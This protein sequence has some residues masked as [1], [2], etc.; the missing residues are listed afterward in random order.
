MRAKC[1]WLAAMAGAMALAASVS[2]AAAGDIRPLQP[3]A[4][5]L[6][7]D[8]LRRSPS[9]AALVADLRESDVVVYVDLEGDER[10]LLGALRF[11]GAAGGTRF[12]RVWLQPRSSDHELV[13]LL[14]HE[15]QHAVELAR[16]PSARS[17]EAFE[18]LFQAIGRSGR[19][20]RYETGAAQEVA[21]RV[22]GELRTG[23]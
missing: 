8:G 6:L 16:T 1:G 21:E 23:R 17:P 3:R 7:E 12:V 5:R 14:A 22:R 15:L 10:Q 4:G 2:D 19:P 13:P 9:L 20:G 18:A 11:M